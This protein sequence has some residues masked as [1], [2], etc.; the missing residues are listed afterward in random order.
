LLVFLRSI[1]ELRKGQKTKTFKKH[2]SPSVD[3]L[4][5]L[6]FSLVYGIKQHSIDVAVKTDPE[7]DQWIFAILHFAKECKRGEVCI[8]LSTPVF[9]NNFHSFCFMVCSVFLF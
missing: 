1:V 3:T 9:D 4:A 2:K 6:S 8:Y 5:F 7:F